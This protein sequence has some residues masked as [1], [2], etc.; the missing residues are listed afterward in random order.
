VKKTAPLDKE[1]AL[2]LI[3]TLAPLL[4]SRK[5][6]AAR[7]VSEVRGVFESFPEEAE[8]IASDIEN[9]D[10]KGAEKTL[11]ALKERLQQQ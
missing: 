5:A 4:S 3:E 9:F 10:Y 7:Y 6:T 1:A 2:R 8:S 11:T